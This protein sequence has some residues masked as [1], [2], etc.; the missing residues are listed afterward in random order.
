MPTQDVVQ[1][2]STQ[3]ILLQHD[4]ASCPY[5]TYSL[6]QQQSCLGFPEFAKIRL[7]TLDS[8]L[9]S[10]TSHVCLYVDRILWGIW[11]SYYNIPKAIKPYSTLLKGDYS[12]RTLR[13][14][15]KALD[16]S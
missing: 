2:A 5:P 13:D 11:G 14:G 16:V 12:S 3:A 1:E 15:A 10:R 8:R 4:H 7:Y 6:A 9:L